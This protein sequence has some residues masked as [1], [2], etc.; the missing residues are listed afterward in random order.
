MQE[1][2]YLMRS[3][4]SKAAKNNVW[5][6]ST[7]E[8]GFVT[9]SS[10]SAFKG[11]E[12]DFIILTDIED[13]EQEWWRS[14]VYVGMSRARVSLHVLLNKSL[15]PTYEMHLRHWLEESTLTNPV[16]METQNDE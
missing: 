13:L 1:K 2:S 4:R 16:S 15:K 7:G 12:N 8:Y 14:V 3:H 11:L 10:V 6:I 9:Y 5:N